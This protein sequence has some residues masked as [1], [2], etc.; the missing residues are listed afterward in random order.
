MIGFVACGHL[1][2][3]QII[4]DLFLFFPRKLV[5]SSSLNHFLLL[6]CPT[7]VVGLLFFRLKK[8][9]DHVYS[10]QFLQLADHSDGSIVEGGRVIVQ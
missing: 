10:V 2:I 5:S 8:K 6:C 1:W 3:L 7:D 4:I 9:N